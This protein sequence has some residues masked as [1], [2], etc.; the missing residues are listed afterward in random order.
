[1]LRT[2]EVNENVE[3]WNRRERD[4]GYIFISPSDIVILSFI[5]IIMCS[6]VIFFLLNSRAVFLQCI[7]CGGVKE[8]AVCRKYSKFREV[9]R[10]NGAFARHQLDQQRVS[11]NI[12]CV[13]SQFWNRL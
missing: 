1:M 12:V 5:Y 3:L 13:C 11:T 2:I 6:S 9:C 10:L 8:T 7:R 4:S